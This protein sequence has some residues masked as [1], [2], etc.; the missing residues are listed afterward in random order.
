MIQKELRL[1]RDYKNSKDFAH[2]A[3]L[4]EISGKEPMNNDCSKILTIV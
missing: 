3:H 4:N 1:E 2:I